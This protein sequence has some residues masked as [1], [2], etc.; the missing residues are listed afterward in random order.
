MI[1]Q[2][3]Y[4]SPKTVTLEELGPRPYENR[5]IRKRIDACAFHIYAPWVKRG[6]VQNRAALFET[7]PKTFARVSVDEPSALGL[8][9]ISPPPAIV[10][11]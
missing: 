10:V 6:E 9:S 2:R 5:H 3:L 11:S 1:I 7:R 8:N 4:R